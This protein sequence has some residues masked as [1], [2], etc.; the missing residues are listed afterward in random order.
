MKSIVPTAA[1]L[2]CTLLTAQVSV[3]ACY[4]SGN[5]KTCTDDSG[6]SYNVR[7]FGNTTITNG[8]NPNTGSQWSQ[9]SNTIGNT[10]FHNGV[11][12]NGNAWKG[13]STRI[14]STTIHQGVD[15]NGNI[16]SKTCN[17]FGCN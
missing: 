16:Y 10:T 15:S 12:A 5:F 13:T 8:Y 7:Q 3:A 11:D 9:N 14:G 6:N 17:Q 2:V 4:G 1:L